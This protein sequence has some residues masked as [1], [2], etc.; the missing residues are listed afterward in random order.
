MRPSS[1]FAL[2]K[3]KMSSC[4][5][6]STSTH[7]PLMEL[8]EAA[9]SLISP[10]PRSVSSSGQSQ[11]RSVCVRERVCAVCVWRE[12][13]RKVSS[14]RCLLHVQQH[15]GVC[16]RPP[17]LAGYRRGLAGQ[18][19]APCSERGN[20]GLKGLGFGCTC[21]PSDPTAV[22]HPPVP[23]NI[24]FKAVPTRRVEALRQQSLRA[25]RLPGALQGLWPL[26]SALQGPGER[27]P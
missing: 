25:S 14:I 10:P 27:G 20:R 23:A 26:V 5:R 11:D 21:R 16:A 13:E 3:W 17:Q 22:P 6:F 8:V 12:E 15:A 24:C 7:T 18:Q 19:W 9:L 4:P 2:P 1:H